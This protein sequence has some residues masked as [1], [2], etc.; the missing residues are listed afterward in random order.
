MVRKIADGPVAT[1]FTAE[2]LQATYGGRPTTSHLDEILSQKAERVGTGRGPRRR[3]DPFPT[4]LLLSAGYNTAVV[5]IGAALLGA[6]AATV[7]TYVLLR[8]RALV[9]D[10]ISQR[11]A[12]RACASP[13]WAQPGHREGRSIVALTAAHVAASS[14]SSG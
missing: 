14:P 8:K 4:A 11:D 3:R 12:S 7:G 5:S 6:S 2:N 1:T 13:S 10:A 9:S